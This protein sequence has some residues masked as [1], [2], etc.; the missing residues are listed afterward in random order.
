MANQQLIDYIKQQMQLGVPKDSIKQ[1]LVT[2]GWPEGD[3]QEGFTAIAGPAVIQPQASAPAVSVAQPVTS[4]IR[5][6]AQSSPVARRAESAFQPKMESYVPSEIT[7]Q[8]SK[9]GMRSFVLPGIMGLL[10]VGLLAATGYLYTQ[11]SSLSGDISKRSLS[12]SDLSVQLSAAV[13]EKTNLA[14]DLAKLKDEAADANSHFVLLLGSGASSTPAVAISIRGTLKGDDKTPYTL[15]TSKGLTV[16]LKNYKAVNVANVL[17]PLVGTSVLISGTAVPGSKEV[18][19]QSVNGTPIA[20]ELPV[21]PPA[22]STST[23]SS[24]PAKPIMP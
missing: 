15:A 6:P 24:T 8:G 11:N 10:I 23:P 14:T 20:E 13:Q 12:N 21:P 3:I 5:E 7:S 19:V 1:T 16:G 2:S 18:I 17:K 22:A 4:D 9:R